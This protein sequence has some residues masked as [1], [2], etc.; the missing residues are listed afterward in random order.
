MGTVIYEISTSVDGF[1][2]A[3]EPPMDEPMGAGGQQ[4]CAW[5]S[6]DND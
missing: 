2:T 4:L 5:T 6:G 1:T 3:I